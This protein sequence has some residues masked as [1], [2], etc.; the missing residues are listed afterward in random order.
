MTDIRNDNSFSPL[1]PNELR[2][3]RQRANSKRGVIPKRSHDGY[4]VLSM[5]QTDEPCIVDIPDEGFEDRPLEWLRTHSRLKSGR[6]SLKVWKSIIQTPYP[7]TLPWGV[8]SG[9][10]H[11]DLLFTV[12]PDLG[13]AGINEIELTEAVKFKDTVFR[14]NGIANLKSSFW[15]IEI[16]TLSPLFI[17]EKRI[18]T[19]F[20]KPA[21]NE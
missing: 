1:T 7:A 19:N 4:I 2:I 12:L 16:C 8:I 3:M 15:E 11:E 13:C 9:Q 21:T 6:Q 10:I 5:R 17:S 20:L 18:L 14:M